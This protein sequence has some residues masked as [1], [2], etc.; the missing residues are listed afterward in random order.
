MNL[1]KKYLPICND[2]GFYMTAGTKSNDEIQ[3]ITEERTAYCGKCDKSVY[4]VPIEVIKDLVQHRFNQEIGMVQRDRRRVKKGS[5]MQDNKFLYLIIVLIPLFIVVSMIVVW[6]GLLLIGAFAVALILDYQ[7]KSK[8]KKDR[9][10][11]RDTKKKELTEEKLKSLSELS[12]AQKDFESLCSVCDGGV[13]P[14]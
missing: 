5:S 3:T 6:L 13:N 7:S 11:I 2:C 9:L 8:L 10:A 14:K 1:D 12:K 4:S